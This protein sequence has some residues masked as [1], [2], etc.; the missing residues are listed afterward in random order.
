[1]SSKSG[2]DRKQKWYY[3]C[4]LWHEE[5]Q[6]YGSEKNGLERYGSERNELERY[7]SESY[8]PGQRARVMDRR[9][10]AQRGS[11]DGYFKSVAQRGSNDG[12]FKGVAQRGISDGYCMAQRR[13]IKGK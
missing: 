6:I 2:S 11:N 5:S 8:G 3:G 12:Y 4:R 1:M 7:G 13:E 10:V 9:G